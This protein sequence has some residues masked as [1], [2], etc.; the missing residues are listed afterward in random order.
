LAVIALLPY[1]AVRI[2]GDPRMS[3]IENPYA[4]EPTYQEPPKTSGLA[5][6]ALILSLVGIIPC[7]GLL[8]APIGFLLGLIGAVTI[9]GNPNRKGVGLAVAAIVIGGLL[10]LGQGYGTYWF[11]SKVGG[12]IQKVMSGPNDALQAGLNGDIAAFKAEFYGAGATAADAEAQAFLD[13]LTN[14]Y[15]DFVSCRFDDTSGQAAQPAPG[16]TSLPFPYVLT[17][18][19]GTVNAETEIV[20]G[21]QNTGAAFINKLGYILVFDPDRGDLRYPPAPAA[22]N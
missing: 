17:F 16:Q 15:G 4:S 11:S 5:I 1:D 13:E 18:S 2:D 6:T 14:R 19:S 21:D 10:A 3:Q 22:G 20:F 12:A 8:T 7:V 9:G